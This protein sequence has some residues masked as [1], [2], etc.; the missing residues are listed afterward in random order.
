MSGLKRLVR[1]HYYRGYPSGLGDYFR[2]GIIAH[3]YYKMS[4]DKDNIK[5]D[6]SFFFEGHPLDKYLKAPEFNNSIYEKE[7]ILKTNSYELFSKVHID[8][9]DKKEFKKMIDDAVVSSV[10]KKVEREY[11]DYPHDVAIHCRT[12][13]QFTKVNNPHVRIKDY[14]DAFKSIVDLRKNIHESLKIRL[15][16]DNLELRER[17]QLS[18]LD[19]K[20]GYGDI[21][22]TAY[23]AGDK[24]YDEKDPKDTIV[25]FMLLMKSSII[26][27]FLSSADTK[28]YLSTFSFFPAYLCNIPIRV[29]YKDKNNDTKCNEVWNTVL[30]ENDYFAEKFVSDDDYTKHVIKDKISYL[31]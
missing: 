18:G 24:L 4:Y 15:F 29:V 9:V 5:N 11:N 13:D 22:H 27:T 21:M 17:V 2:A 25:D 7:G 1:H 12:G 14:D 30:F 3:K 23:D 20:C 8:E 10:H 31:E 26:Y 28:R 16:T 6:Y 19:I